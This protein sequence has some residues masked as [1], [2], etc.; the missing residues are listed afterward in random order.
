MPAIERD[1]SYEFTVT[2]IAFGGDGVGR[3]DGC[4]VFVPFVA[5]GERVR[6][7]IWKRRSRYYF[8]DLE[9]VLEPVA[10]RS[11]PFCQFYG[12]CG[13]C[14]YQHLAYATQLAVK[15]KQLRDI[16]V[17]IGG[18]DEDVKVEPPIASPRT[19]RYRNR[20]DLHPSEEAYYG[21]CV[22][23][24]PRQTFRV[25]DCPLFELEQDLSD[26]PLRQEDHLLVVR[27]HDGEPYCYF[28]DDHNNVRSGPFDLATQEPRA[29]EEITFTVGDMTLAAH[30]G[31][32]FQVNRWVLPEFVATVRAVA[33]PRA[34]DTLLDVYCG[35]GLFGLA[36]A[37]EVARV[38]GVEL[39]EGCIDLARRNADRMGIEN[40]EFAAAKAETYLRGLVD[41]GEQA[42]LCIVDPPR[43]G[44]T[45]KVVSAL[46]HLRPERLVYVSCGPD[47]FARDARKF[48][49]LGYRLETIQPLDLFPHTKHVELVARLI[50]G[51]ET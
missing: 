37:H 30:Y 35:V 26:Y 31:G 20:I 28:K 2:D 17:R 36:L 34:D 27:T 15:Q 7:R 1:N 41:A 39:L 12:R 25:T 49:D 50:D 46:K 42:S 4:V 32:F 40:T 29:S 9:E 24:R 3:V 5:A 18:F 6:A 48:V 22:R 44:L 38:R 43:N 11:E 13:G 47:T 23:G 33:Q 45:N 21:F 10:E 51:G 19:T 16:M 8:A 14:Q